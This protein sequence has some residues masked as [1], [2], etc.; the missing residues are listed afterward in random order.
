MP[1]PR[2]CAGERGCGIL[3][4]TVCGASRSMAFEPPAPR[5]DPC[6]RRGPGG[7]TGARVARNRVGRP[8]RRHRQKPLG[9][10]HGG[11]RHQS[12]RP[13]IRRHPSCADPPGKP[14]SRRAG[15][16]RIPR[17]SGAGTRLGT[18]D[19]LPPCAGRGRNRQPGTSTRPVFWM[20]CPVGEPP[21][22]RHK[23]TKTAT[24]PMFALHCF[25]PNRGSKIA[26]SLIEQKR[27]NPYGSRDSSDSPPPIP[28]KKHPISDAKK[29]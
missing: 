20:T 19:F 13:K 9:H 21:Q 10:G 24:K 29:V 7:G 23:N 18:P 28:T 15:N 1:A 16:T 26:G 4:Q 17:A 14:P 11:C 3:P 22:N 12:R 5:L 6:V 25:T 27:A 2:P 8:E